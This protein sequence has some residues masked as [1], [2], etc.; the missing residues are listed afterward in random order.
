M[1]MVDEARVKLCVELFAE[2]EA[3]ALAPEA[4]DRRRATA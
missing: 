2:A 3:A 1:W 4:V